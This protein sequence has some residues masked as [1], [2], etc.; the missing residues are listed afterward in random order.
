MDE[1]RG[2]RLPAG[3]VGGR[4]WVLACDDDLEVLTRYGDF[5]VACAVFVVHVAIAGPAHDTG[6]RIT[7][8]FAGRVTAQGEH[9]GVVS[10]E[11]DDHTAFAVEAQNVLDDVEVCG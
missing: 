7:V 1:V 11:P 6:D 3:G 8:A 10:A 9:C 4:E 2:E 5:C